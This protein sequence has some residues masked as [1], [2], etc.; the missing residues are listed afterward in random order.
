MN[1]VP[2]PACKRVSRWLVAYDVRGG[3]C[4]SATIVAIKRPFKEGSH[5]SPPDDVIC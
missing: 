3:C 4:P 1:G 2:I 5:R